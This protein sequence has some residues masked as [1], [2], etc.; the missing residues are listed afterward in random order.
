MG[1]G[2]C[3]YRGGVRAGWQEEEHDGES[4]DGGEGETG[5]GVA[6]AE[7]DKLQR[8]VKQEADRELELE[9]GADFKKPN[10]AA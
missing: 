4:V 3:R 9:V 1:G 5:G 7:G 8:G 10:V 6:V 2:W